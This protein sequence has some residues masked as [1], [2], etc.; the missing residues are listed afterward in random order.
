MPLDGIR[1]VD[2][3]RAHAGYICT[4]FLGFFGAE[5]IKIES[6][7]LEN[8]RT[9]GQTG[10]ED[11]NRNKL[12]STIDIRTPDGKAVLLDLVRNSDVVVEHFR[13][14]VMDRLGLDYQALKAAK[15]DIIMLSM[16]GMGA[17]GPIREYR[18]YGQQV[19]GM[20]GL[21]HLWGHPDGALNTRVKMPFPD[22]VAAILGAT[23]IVTAL[24][25]REKTGEGQAIE[26]A[27][28]EGQAHF[29]GPAILD[30]TVN[31]TK[32]RPIGNSSETHA[33][34][35]V[36]PCFGIDA[37][38]AIAVENDDQ[39]RAL[40]EVLGSPGWASEERFATLEGRIANKTELDENLSEWTRPLTPL[41]AARALQVGGVPASAVASAEDLYHDPH[42]RS[43]VEGIVAIDH[44][45]VGIIEHQGINANLS[46]TP[47]TSKNPAPAKGEHN[48]H[49][50]Q[51][52]LGLS[53]ARR[54][55]LIE[56]GAFR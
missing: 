41:L 30:Y 55:E 51:E 15:D 14:G 35:D 49:V 33:P 39:W 44:P 48:V 38:C 22:Y 13:P 50:F 24:E 7:G 18:S 17:S 26:I 29:L 27:Q 46:L 23:A 6:D 37:W 9:P 12:S 43:R 40:G 2:L 3:T 19:M 42:L 53:E 31:G 20:T 54:Q 32:P 56:S 47:G 11:M 25:H 10:F 5:V 36:Y 45:D 8:P 21:T 28:L 34:H 16:P 1:I 52:L 4:E